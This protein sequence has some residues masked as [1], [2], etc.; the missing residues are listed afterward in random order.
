MAA[1]AVGGRTL[2]LGGGRIGTGGDAFGLGSS[3]L[4]RSGGRCDILLGTFEGEGELLGID[5]F[6]SA[7]EVGAL[8]LPD[9]LFQTGCFRPSFV[10]LNLAVGQFGHSL[11]VS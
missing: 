8:E 11:A 2:G 1:V 5:P 9:H 4:D 7:A 3:S 6:R 10:K